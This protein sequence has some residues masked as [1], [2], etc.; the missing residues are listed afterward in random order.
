MVESRQNGD[1]SFEVFES[2]EFVKVFFL[3]E[4]DGNFS[5]GLLVDAHS[6]NSVG[7]FAQLAKNFVLFDGFLPLDFDIEGQ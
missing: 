2:I 5:S 7:S 4:F 3:V 6:N 1:L